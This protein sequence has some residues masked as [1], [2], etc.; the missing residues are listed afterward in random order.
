MKRFLI[1]L[2][3][4]GL[5]L[6]CWACTEQESVTFYYVREQSAYLSGTS[7]GVIVGEYREAAGHV[8]DLRYLLILYLH[9]PVGE[10]LASPFPSGTSLVSLTETED[11]LTIQLSS[12]ASAM[13]GTDLTLAC[14]CIAQTCFSITDVQS[15][16]VIASGFGD[17]SMTMTRDSLLLLDDAA[18]GADR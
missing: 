2:L 14:A 6:S 16:T 8:H 17:V 15:V 11:A 5:M 1:I 9:G 12:I 10:N 18:V 7:N 4:V 13:K 3:L